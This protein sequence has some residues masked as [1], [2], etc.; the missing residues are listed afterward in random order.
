VLKQRAG[1]KDDPVPTTCWECGRALSPE[2]RAFCSDDCADSYRQAM[3]KR[4][5]VVEPVAHRSRKQHHEATLAGRRAADN[6]PASNRKALRHWYAENLQ[7]RLSRMHPTEIALGAAMGRSYAYYVVAGT[8][9]P[10]PRHFP[11]LAAL[12]GVEL[13]KEFAAELSSRDELS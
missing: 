3:G 6:M 4:R 1:V 9:I 7:P 8:R 2:R 13:P 10:H 5:P 11:S 12:V